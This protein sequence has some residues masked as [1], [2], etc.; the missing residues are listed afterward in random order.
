[1][2]SLP[3]LLLVSG[4]LCPIWSAAKGGEVQAPGSLI[5]FYNVKLV[6]SAAPH[7]GCGSASKPIL[8]E[9]EHN[10]LVSEAWL[11]R[12][13]TILAV[14]WEEKVSARKRAKVVSAL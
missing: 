4:L 6:C 9:L 7:I 3:G 11:N 1:M 2:K 12:P 13:G 5:S 8:L 10:P 14:V